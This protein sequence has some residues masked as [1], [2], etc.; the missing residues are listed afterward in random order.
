[1]NKRSIELTWVAVAI[2]H[3]AEAAPRPG[4]PNGG[5]NRASWLR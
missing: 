3:T 2:T 1:M 4:N 5:V